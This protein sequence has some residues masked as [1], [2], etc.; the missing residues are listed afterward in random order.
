MKGGRQRERSSG[1]MCS[2]DSTYFLQEGV[3]GE[4]S[5]VSPS[6]HMHVFL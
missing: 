6:V 5:V 2:V 3:G 1:V 4:Y